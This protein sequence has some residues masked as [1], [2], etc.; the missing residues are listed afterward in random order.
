MRDLQEQAN[1]GTYG[2]ESLNAINA[3]CNALVDEINRLYLGSEY[4]GINLFL[5]TTT[6]AGGKAQILQEVIADSSK[7]RGLV[8][9]L[10]RT[11]SA[12]GASRG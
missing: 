12:D 3:E 8:V 2:A 1:N 7:Y 6:D 10:P 4:N 11:G 5:E 9:R